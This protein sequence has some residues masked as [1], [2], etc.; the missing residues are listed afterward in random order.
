M[1]YGNNGVV[2][3]FNYGVGFGTTFNPT[4]A[5]KQKQPIATLG[6]S[7]TRH[8]SVTSSGLMQVITERVDRVFPLEFPMV[9]QSDLAGWDAFITWAIQGGQFQ[10]IPDST[11]TGTYVVCQI[12]STDVPPKWV[13]PGFF[14]ISIECRVVVTAQVGS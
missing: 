11:D 8:D 5:A 1:S 7:A 12:T 3:Q 10:Y 6:Q 4:Y 9:P 13:S 2:P 14:T